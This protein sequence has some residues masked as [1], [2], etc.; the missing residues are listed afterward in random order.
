M[1]RTHIIRKTNIVKTAR[2]IQLESLFEIPPSQNSVNEWYIDLDLPE[3]WNVGLIIGASGSGKT[4]VARE[5]FSNGMIDSF[6]W[7]ASKSI[8]DAFP[9]DMSIKDITALLSSVGFSSPPSW[10][11]PFHA[12]S[13]GEQ[14]R[15]FIARALAEKPD[16]AVIDE[17]TSVV[18]RTVAK[19]ASAAIQK[20]VRRRDQK[21]VAVSVHYDIA[22]WLE[23]D[24]VYEP[25]INKLTVGRSLRRPEIKLTIKRVHSSAWQLFKRH[26]YLDTNINKAAICFCAFWDDIPVAFCSWLPFPHPKL[27][28]TKREHRTVTLPDYQGIGIGNVL[29]NYCAS[30]IKT[31]GY[32]VISSTGNPAMIYSRNKSKQWKMTSKPKRTAKDKK[33]KGMKRA[34]NRLTCSFRYV[35]ENIDRDIAAKMLQTK[36]GKK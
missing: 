12:L 19:V 32:N 25:A 30:I 26:H 4:T 31:M 28:N 35:G 8:I 11:R 6:D 20:T 3:S 33:L 13:N 29:S 9:T 16:L 7:D 10:L 27:K 36:K 17:F 24:W 34:T 18:D 21:F 2:V 1:P 23:P 15:A 14:F 5:L 22:E